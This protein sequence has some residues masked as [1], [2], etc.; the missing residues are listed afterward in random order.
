MADGIH[1]TPKEIID[2]LLEEMEQGICP[3]FYSNLVP[4]VFDVYVYVDDLERLQPLQKRMREEA[5][6]ALEEKLG[7]LNKAAEPKLKLPL[8]AKKRINR[9]ETLGEWSV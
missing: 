5:V 3:S 6:T 2:F 1:V 8:S 7:S 4:N 9:Y